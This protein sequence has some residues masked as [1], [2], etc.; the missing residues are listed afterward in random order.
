[1]ATEGSNQREY[2]EGVGM[3]ILFFFTEDIKH[4]DARKARFKIDKHEITLNYAFHI[5]TFDKKKYLKYSV[6]VLIL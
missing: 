5:P 4:R 3:D 1:M 6:G 2:L